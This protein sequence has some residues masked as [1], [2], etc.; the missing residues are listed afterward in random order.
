MLDMTFAQ[1]NSSEKMVEFENLLNGEVTSIKAED[2][3]AW[4]LKR[5]LCRLELVASR[6]SAPSHL[7]RIAEAPEE[8]GMFASKII[9]QTSQ[10]DSFLS[11]ADLH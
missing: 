1:N 9:G 11:F 10:L 8:W 6:L 7:A 2:I 3:K 4:E 5:E